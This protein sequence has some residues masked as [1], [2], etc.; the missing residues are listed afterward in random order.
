M[1]HMEWLI[2][3]WSERGET[4]L[5]P[6]CGSGTIPLAAERMQRDGIGIEI[7]GRYVALAKQRIAD[8]APLFPTQDVGLCV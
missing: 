6:F 2:D 4:I 3:W 1:V 5:D 8:D 7:E